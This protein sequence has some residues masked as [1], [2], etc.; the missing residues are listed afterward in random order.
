MPSLTMRQT[1]VERQRVEPPPTCSECSETTE[2]YNEQA[3]VCEPCWD[4]SYEEC[5][6]C[7]DAI[8]ID[9]WYSNSSS[10]TYCDSCFYDYYSYCEHCSEPVENDNAIYLNDGMYCVGCEPDESGSMISSF[11]NS[12]PPNYSRT[13]STFTYPI[14]RLV[15]VEVECVIP[16]YNY[17]CESPEFWQRHSDGSISP[18]EEYVGVE[19]V[20][21]PANGDLL[22]DSLSKLMRWKRNNDVTVNRSCGLHVHFNS[23]DMSA[24]EVAHVGIVYGRLQKQIK[25]MMPKSRQDSNWCKDFDISKDTLLRI[26]SE[27]GLIDTYYDYMD[28][29]PS[30]DKYND[31]RYS[32]LNIHSRY[33]HGTIE[34][35]LHSGTINKEKILNWISILNVI[36]I[37]GIELSRCSKEDVNSWF[38]K[39]TEDILEMFGL[40]LLEY[41]HKRTTKFKNEFNLELYEE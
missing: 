4:E 39:P 10:D 17:E 37:K 26:N 28:S 31:A 18:P 6:C 2:I 20:S 12:C 14:K 1:P 41:M 13:S 40:Y 24:R 11:T 5:V 21:Y 36:V 25:S 7:S 29:E 23:T 33:Y 35:R 3:M 9:D 19:M 38:N 22:V 30:S 8:H 15:G 32:A 16:R 34:F 27:S